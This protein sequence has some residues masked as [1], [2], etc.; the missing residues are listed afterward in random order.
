MK[1]T[2]LSIVVLLGLVGCINCP[3]LPH[4]RAIAHSTGKMGMQYSFTLYLPME[5]NS[6]SP[7][8][9]CPKQEYQATYVYTDDLGSVKREDLIWNIRLFGDT[10]A[11]LPE[12]KAIQQRT[13]LT[14]TKNTVTV[15]GITGDLKPYNGTYKI[16]TSSP[17]SWGIEIV[18]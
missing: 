10:F 2:I 18:K 13:T 11:S 1:K 6:H 4:K 8:L 15:Q 16:E 7:N 14:F 12:S 9:K 3:S 17:E 5:G